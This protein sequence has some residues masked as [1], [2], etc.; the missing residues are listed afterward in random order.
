MQRKIMGES[1]KKAKEH[2][3]KIGV[4]DVVYLDEVGDW[5][6][7][8]CIESRNCLLVGTGDHDSDGPQLL[9]INDTEGENIAEMFAREFVGIDVMQHNA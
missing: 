1:G 8:M 3:I 2:L 6:L 4:P 9:A 7:F 5:A